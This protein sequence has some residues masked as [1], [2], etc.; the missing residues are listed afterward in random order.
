MGRERPELGR[1]VRVFPHQR[2]MVL[3]TWEVLSCQDL[4]C[5]YTCPCRTSPRLT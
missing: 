5:S 3:E 1:D 2:S 4:T